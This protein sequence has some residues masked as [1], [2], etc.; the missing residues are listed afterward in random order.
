MNGVFGIE[1]KFQMK[2]LQNGK[3]YLKKGGLEGGT[4]SYYYFPM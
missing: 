4:Y 2:R 1:G 3:N